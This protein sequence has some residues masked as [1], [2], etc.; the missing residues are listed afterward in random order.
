M[1][2]RA[3]LLAR[4]LGGHKAGNSWT[5]RCPAH[6][7]GTPSLSI[8]QA[9]ARVLVHC[10][11]GCGQDRVLAVLRERKLWCAGSA[12]RRLPP[13]PPK[14]PR[15]ATYALSIWRAAR[16]ARGTPVE[17]YL[18]LRGLRLPGDATLRFHPNLRHRE[19]GTWWPAMVALVRHGLDGTA[20]AIHRTY[21]A[22]DGRAKAPLPRPRLAL[23]PCRGGAARLAEAGP[24]LLVGEG[25]ET[26]LSAMQ[27]TGLPVWSALSTS[28]MALLDLPAAVRE[29]IVL[30]DGDDPGERAALAAARRWQGEGRIARI[31]R[32]P[33][34]MD[35]NDMLLKR[36]TP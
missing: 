6:E 29:V 8:T 12:P 15:P 30:A 26:C 19:S 16:D 2:T 27:A 21:L 22:R 32:P 34:G 24:I 10:H 36:S 25:I 5:A 33:R 4:A 1:N 3:E 28:F 17:T 23:G 35:F 13:P 11:A 31:A 18:E 20:Q 7:D 14:A 9:G